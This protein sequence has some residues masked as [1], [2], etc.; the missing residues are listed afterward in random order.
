MRLF[1]RDASAIDGDCELTIRHFP[2]TD[3]S[4][5]ACMKE[6]VTNH[7]EGMSMKAKENFLYRVASAT[8]GKIG[9][10][11]ALAIAAAA[12]DADAVSD[13][14]KAG[15]DMRGLRRG[16]GVHRNETGI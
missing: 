16:D 12:G 6:L 15:A 8:D 3:S 10:T 2:L 11:F 13:M 5:F 7:A 9:K 14:Q 4:R 1:R